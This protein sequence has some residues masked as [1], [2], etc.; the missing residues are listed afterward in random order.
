MKSGKEE[1]GENEIG[2]MRIFYFFITTFLARFFSLLMLFCVFE[3]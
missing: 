1:E 3:L 2:C